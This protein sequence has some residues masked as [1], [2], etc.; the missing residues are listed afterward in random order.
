MKSLF[1]ISLLIAAV[2]IVAVLAVLIFAVNIMGSRPDD[3]DDFQSR[4]SAIIQNEVVSSKQSNDSIPQGTFIYG[5]YFAEWNGR[6]PN[7]PVEVVIKGDKI[8]IS[9]TAETNLTGEDL[10]LESTIRKHTS[11]KWIITDDESDIYSDEIGG[12]S[13]GAIPIDFENKIIKFC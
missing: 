8:T 10:I 4:N 5:L 12:C 7:T 13:G 3:Q 2:L 9:K 1:K 11:G 6:M